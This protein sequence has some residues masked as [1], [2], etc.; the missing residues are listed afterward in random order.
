LRYTLIILFLI[1]LFA[2]LALHRSLG[3]QER[4]TA[5]KNALSLTIITPHNEPIRREFEEAFSDWHQQHFGQPVDINYLSF[6]GA[7]D[8]RRTL[9]AR[10][11]TTFA[12]NGTY[13][14][15]LAWGGGD[16][17]F[18]TILKP[19][20]DGLALDPQLI[21][22]VY[23]QTTLAGLR[24]YDASNPPLWYG[25]CLSSFGIAYNKDVVKFLGVDN[26]RTW[27]DLKDPRYRNWI[28]LADPTR[29]STARTMF[30]VIVERAM[31]DAVAEGRSSDVGWAEG[32]GMVRQICANA[33]NFSDSANLPPTQVSNGEVAAAMTIDFYARSQMQALTDDHMGYVEPANATVINPDPIGMLK[34]APNRELAKRFVEF[35]LS[36][37]GQ[38]LFDLKAG[39]PGGPKTSTLRRLP[40]RQSVYSDMR[41]FADQ[42][43]PFEQ[44]TSFNTARTRTATFDIIGELVQ[45]SCIDV[46][47]DLRE[48]RAAILASKRSRELDQVL[49]KFPYGESAAITL[50]DQYRSASAVERL[51]LMQT[52]TQRFRD[53]YATL[54][55]MAEHAH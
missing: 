53:E 1:V 30:M 49:G 32:M 39:T 43:N 37:Q 11:E 24:L 2:P 7:S 45:A 12:R 4:G 23:P 36:E 40:I 26:P 27:S 42:V 46:L 29:S 38:R 6:G 35:V 41:N 28:L 55:E 22:A 21:K 15:D 20:L 44:T 8:M 18:D 54:R 25:T 48:T 16:T 13:E 10:K 5:P 33:R 9:E 31:V 51:K 19:Y 52:W 34:G 17:L 14:I 50:R 3:R 47:D